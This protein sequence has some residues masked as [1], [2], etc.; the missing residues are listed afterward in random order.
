MAI[1]HRPKADIL[2]ATLS[3]DKM[4][5]EMQGIPSQ[6]IVSYQMDHNA[7]LLRAIVGEMKDTAEQPQILPV[8]LWS[9]GEL[10]EVDGRKARY[11]VGFKELKPG[12]ESSVKL[13][14]GARYKISLQA[15]ERG[16]K[17]YE[18]FAW[19]IDF[20]L[21]DVNGNV[22]QKVETQERDPDPLRLTDPASFRSDYDWLETV[23]YFDAPPDVATVRAELFPAT[24]AHMPHE[25]KP[26][27][28]LWLSDIVITPLGVPERKEKEILVTLA[29]PLAKNAKLPEINTV[30]SNHGIET[31]V[32]HP[33]GTK[34]TIS[35]D[36]N[37]D[38]K[39]LR[40]GD[41]EQRFV[42][43]SET[44]NSLSENQLKANSNESQLRLKDGLEKWTEIVIKERDKYTSK[45]W[46]NIAPDAEVTATGTRDQRFSPTNV[47]DNK[48]WEFPADGRLDYKLGEIQTTQGSGYGKDER[49]SYTDN[50]SSW[51]FYIPPTYW[52]L[53][54]R[55]TGNITLKLKK[56]T[57]IKMVRVLN[58]SNAGLHDYGTI[59][60]QLELLDENQQP[61]YTKEASFGKAWDRA[62][63]SAFAKPD[64]F[65]SYG[66]TFEG[67]LEPGVK[68]PFG[69]GWQDI[70]IDYSGKVRYLR[71]NILSYWAIG[72]GI[73]EIQVYP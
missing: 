7:L 27:S 60:F 31:T 57:R 5:Y 53:P 48:T 69:T 39:I 28:K 40:A 49:M 68:V 24:W 67:I 23:T 29:M 41:I 58:T 25:L 1:G 15:K 50:M 3:Y 20:T 11:F 34:D 63:K 56:G 12:L 4:S 38:Y 65:N 64:F 70:E 46:K 26:D 44:N 73:N 9:E 55:Q 30:R 13:I 2:L 61:V 36:A 6:P 32:I 33:D 42:W 10:S 43:N 62:F 47:V 45:G 66:P 72:G 52:L 21:F 71:L 54:Y 17:V 16:V 18:N 37:G 35:V 8:T 14:P 19:K 59:D 51:P 22:I